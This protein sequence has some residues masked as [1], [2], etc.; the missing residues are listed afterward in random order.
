[1]RRSL[2]DPGVRVGEQITARVVEVKENG[3]WVRHEG[4]TGII[5]IVEWTWCETTRPVPERFATPGE[6]LR[7]LVMTDHESGFSGS[8]KR[9]RPGDDPR[10]H[11]ALHDGSVLSASVRATRPF[12]VFVDLSIGL[13]AM[14]EDGGDGVRDDLEVGRAVRVT[15]TDSDEATG[16]I[17]VRVVQDGLSAD[18]R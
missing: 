7:L 15:V 9:L 1:M 16:K 3:I 14:L 6:D 13:V 2:G 5:P 10:R 4:R 18:G 11:P 12:G 8:L 17:R